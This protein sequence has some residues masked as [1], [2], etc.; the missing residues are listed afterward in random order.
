MLIRVIYAVW[1]FFEEWG[2]YRAKMAM[3]RGHYH[4]Y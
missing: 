2:E 3:K 4:M 1:D